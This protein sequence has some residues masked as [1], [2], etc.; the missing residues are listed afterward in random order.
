MKSIK[1]FK[2]WS[3]LFFL[4]ALV[5]AIQWGIL[6]YAGLLSLVFIFSCMYHYSNEKRWATIDVSF[7]LTLVATNFALMG[8]ARLN[9]I[10]WIFICLAFALLAGVFYFRQFHHGYNLNHGFY[11]VVSAIICVLCLLIYHTHLIAQ[12]T[13]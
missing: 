10:E 13:Q 9:P 8:M 6:W 3:N 12:I 11:H 1:M 2:W 4:V 5:L 7:A